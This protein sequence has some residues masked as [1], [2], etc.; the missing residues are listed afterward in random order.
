MTIEDKTGLTE[1][2]F[3]LDNP[4]VAAQIL[5]NSLEVLKDIAYELKYNQALKTLNYTEEL[6]NEKKIE[7]DSLQL[8]IAELKDRNQSL[9]TNKANIL[10]ESTQ[11]EFNIVYST[12][13]DLAK[14]IESAK[15]GVK[16]SSASYIVLHPVTI[17]RGTSMISTFSV[18]LIFLLMGLVIGLFYLALRYYF[19]DLRNMYLEVYEN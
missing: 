8:A 4:V 17:P 19:L 18:T 10:L 13:L 16:E 5:L 12:F 9:S 15:L 7:I 11:N 2:T 3:S 14:Q 1:V 6:Y